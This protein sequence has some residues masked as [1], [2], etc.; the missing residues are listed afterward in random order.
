MSP[1][2]GF[3]LLLHVAFPRPGVKSR[4]TEVVQTARPPLSLSRGWGV[5]SLPGLLCHRLP[6]RLPV[7]Q[8]A[9]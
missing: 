7:H 5:G 3:R 8:K 4:I 9:S 1:S 2:R 6:L